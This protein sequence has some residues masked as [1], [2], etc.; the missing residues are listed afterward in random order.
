MYLVAGLL[1][2]SLFAVPRLQQKGR[3]KTAAA[4]IRIALGSQNRRVI[5]DQIKEWSKGQGV[6][7]DCV[8]QEYEAARDVMGR[9][10]DLVMADDPWIAAWADQLIPVNHSAI[11]AKRFPNNQFESVF[12]AS[13][14]TCKDGDK[15]LGFPILGNVLLLYYR[16]DMLNNAGISDDVVRVA[17]KHP[18][19]FRDRFLNLADGGNRRFLLT[20]NTTPADSVELFWQVLLALGYT[21][22]RFA[23]TKLVIPKDLALRAYR[24]LKD[25]DPK[26]FEVE[27]DSDATKQ[28]LDDKP[29]GP[30]M[31]FAWAGWFAED[32]ASDS[33]FDKRVGAV[34]FGDH[35]L[36]GHWVLC[37]PHGSKHA[38][39]VTRLAA[40]LALDKANTF[41]RAGSMPATNQI[42]T[43]DRN[44]AVA[45]FRD[46]V[47]P[48]L[49]T[50]LPRPRTKNWKEIED[51]LNA[52]IREGDFDKECK[53]I[54]FDDDVRGT[55]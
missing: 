40:H 36:L 24:W 12:P 13:A 6:R 16:R 2:V 3:D 25:V 50:A 43:S 52:A 45:H 14:K 22:P 54:V 19:A 53:Y 10:F 55:P 51:E 28:F 23:K 1:V 7:V 5:E 9:N 34:P 32:F 11:F 33:E 20:C 18:D 17:A 15:V 42:D 27:T 31:M 35:P 30:L 48:A 47:L 49:R 26:G 37:V 44:K 39:E 4:P 8:P 46:I 29:D 38:D 21:E 41:L